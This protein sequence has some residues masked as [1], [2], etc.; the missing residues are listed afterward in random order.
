MITL[1]SPAKINLF[2]EVLNK[3]QDGYHDIQSIMQTIDLKDTIT[4]KKI[5]HGIKILSSNSQIPIDENNL[6]FKAAKILLEKMKIKQG[7]EIKIDKQIPIKAGLGGG[8]SNAATT[9]KGINSLFNLNLGVEELQ[10][11]GAEIGS[12]VPFFI[13]GGISK[14]LGKGE[15]IIPLPDLPSVW[16]ILVKPEIGIS[17]KKVYEELDKKN[18]TPKKNIDNI[19]VA[20]KTG[21]IDLLGENLFNRFEDII[22]YP[23]IL[24]IK[25]TMKK[26]GI[27]YILMTGTGSTIFG[28]VKEKR[29]EIYEKLSKIFKY[30][31]WTKNLTISIC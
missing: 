8:S 31:F 3:R 27:N 11:I 16:F 12:D 29:K 4:I 26:I 21:N 15:I 19:I 1:Y 7:V 5:N 28:I 2:L 23:E 9:L 14:I 6:C 17:T 30:V 10:N 13:R 24:T 25:K 22:K 20:I 18:M